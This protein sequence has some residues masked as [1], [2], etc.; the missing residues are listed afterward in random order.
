MYEF[1]KFSQ[2]KK[3]FISETR[4]IYETILSKIALSQE[5]LEAIW[6]KVQRNRSRV[7][8]IYA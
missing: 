6:N 7:L 5:F 3:R 2:L 4:I 1:Y 8:C